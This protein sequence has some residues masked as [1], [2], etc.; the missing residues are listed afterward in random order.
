MTKSKIMTAE[1]D[2]FS[3]TLN[4]RSF[5][6]L[7]SFKSILMFVFPVLKIKL[8]QCFSSPP[9]LRKSVDMERY[10][11]ISIDDRTEI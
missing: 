6:Y 11:C 10:K 7:G 9:V 8:I 1:N 2:Y 3:N 4:S 5:K